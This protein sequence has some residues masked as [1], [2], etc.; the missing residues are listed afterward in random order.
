MSIAAH[1][2]TAG[3]PH[4]IF[5]SPFESWRQF[6]PNGMVLKSERFASN[7]WDSK[8]IFTFES[9]CRS[10]NL[11]Y[12]PVGDPLPLSL[13]LRYGEWF[14]ENT[15]PNLHEVKVVNIQHISKN[16]QLDL[17]DGRTLTSRR[18]VLATGHMAYRV[19]P[20]PLAELSEPQVMH[21]TGIGDVARYAGRR[22][23]IIGGGQSALETAALL[24]ES[25]AH[26]RILARRSRIEW[27]APSQPRAFLKR[28]IS[29]D[30]GIASGWKSY[31]ISEFPRTFRW[32]F[33]PTKR[34]RFVATSYGPS[35]A[36][37]LRQRVDGRIDISTNT[38]VEDAS[39]HAGLVTLEI[40][41]P[42]GRHEVT[43]DHVILA[44]G[45]RVDID[46]LKFLDP[47]LR[48]SIRREGA[49]I[50]ALNS[51]LE[52]SVP[53]LTIVGIASAPIFGPIMRFM[54]GAKHAAS[55]VT[56]RLKLR[57]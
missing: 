20:S 19:V 10:H 16:F 49:G 8:R 38:T 42:S 9:Y 55:I 22:I 57:A 35:G 2:R 24:H 44:T 43:A 41:A 29:P 39:E 28:L 12:Q 40:A 56:G 15:A 27:N 21:S 36:W 1:L 25:G 51:H 17:A 37:W 23:I 48:Q 34:H 13:F 50:P 32:R 52:T 53:G 54:Y 33:P 45:F 3:I 47:D 30:A 46:Q 5:G 31:A 7:L 4:E 26:V 11:S 18:I 14:R 6:M